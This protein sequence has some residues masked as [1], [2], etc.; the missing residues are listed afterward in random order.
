[1]HVLLYCCVANRRHSQRRRRARD[2][3]ETEFSSRPC[4]MSHDELVDR[5]RELNPRLVDWNTTQVAHCTFEIPRAKVLKVPP[6]TPSGHP[7][8]RI[9]GRVVVIVGLPWPAT[10]VLAEPPPPPECQEKGKQSACDHPSWATHSYTES[11]AL[12]PGQS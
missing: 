7:N 3:T 12:P 1:M 4:R 2:A 9:S 10:L 6:P 11:G 8:N 5:A